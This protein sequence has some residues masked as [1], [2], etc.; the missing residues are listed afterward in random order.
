MSHFFYKKLGFLRFNFGQ[1][2]KNLETKK[3][4]FFKNLRLFSF[5]G[6]EGFAPP[7]PSR[8]PVLQTGAFACSA[9]YP[10]I[11]YGKLLI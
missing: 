2:L 7:K 10:K 3:M 4:R 1:G 8:A 9:T 5:V 6:R 11:N